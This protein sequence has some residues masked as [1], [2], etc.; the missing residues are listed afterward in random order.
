MDFTTIDFQIA[1]NCAQITINRP[2]ALNALN[3]E[4]FKDLN[5]AL[6]IIE[7]DNELRTVIITGNGKAFVAGADIA[8]MS[9]MTNEQAF[10]FAKTGHDTFNRIANLKIPVIGAINGFAL[11]G[12]CEFAMACDI[13]IANTFA[14]FG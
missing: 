12:G 6:D 14:K 8:E 11:G 9:E 13:R 7:K 4:V 1:D 5:N 2:Q 10:I 3:S